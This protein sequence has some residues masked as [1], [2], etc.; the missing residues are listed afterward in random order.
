MSLSDIL[1]TVGLA[2]SVL[3]IPLTFV[4]ARRTRQRPDL[5]YMLEYDEILRADSNLFG[6]G[7]F[8]TL[9]SHRIDSISRTRV[10]FWNH[11]GDAIRDADLLESDPLRIELQDGDEVL[12]ARVLSMSRKQLEVTA[13]ID[14]GDLSKI[15]I[16]FNFLDVGD[17]AI[18][19]V[20]HRGPSKPTVLGTLQGADI[21]NIGPFW[22]LRVLEPD[23]LRRFAVR[24]RRIGVAI[25]AFL[26]VFAAI[27][28]T[29]AMILPRNHQPYLI[30]AS[31]YNLNTMPGQ[32]AFAAAVSN[33]YAFKT[34]QP[35]LIIVA[36][37]AVLG[38]IIIFCSPRFRRR[39]PFNITSYKVSIENDGSQDVE[40]L[41]PLT[42]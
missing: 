4:L 39:V 42:S 6:R 31:Q 8:M 13:P 19:E 3:G 14:E 15:S 17:G 41:A 33:T 12:Q 1:A 23:R 30:D 10:A 27:F 26:G 25:M 24:R 18:I 38:M 9:G 11:R 16:C 20:I 36:S 2:V 34:L 22:N 32:M 7:L 35:L 28:L 5:R 40:S 29:L 21:R 37:L